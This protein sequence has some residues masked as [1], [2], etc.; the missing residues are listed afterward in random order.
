[1]I[2][3]FSGTGNSKA[4]A[5]M[6]AKQLNDSIVP[7]TDALSLQREYFLRENEPLGFVFPVYSWGPPE[8]VLRLVASLR[9]TSKPSY[10]YFV[11]TCGDDTGKTADIFCKAVAARGWK[12]EA[13][14][15]VTMP[16][17]YV[18]LPGF[19]VDSEEMQKRKIIG[20]SK[21]LID[22][23]ERIKA[24]KK[25]FDCNE[26]A[27]PRLKSYGIRPLFN[28][29]LVNAKHFWVNEDC[30]SCGKCIRVCPTK[31]IKWKDGRPSWGEDCTMCLACYHLCPKHA[32]QYGGQTKK[33]G[34]Y[35][36]PF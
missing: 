27:M 34:Q 2:T 22:L 23:A 5:N 35:K 1:M 29:F 19:D 10:V 12:C 21:R 36:F 26:G 33:K 18:C 17:T 16:N 32:I 25:G 15:S 20:T 24:R 3:V 11:C 13:G 30:I 31:N 14:F 6:L 28:Q 4:V 9:L 8:I 7:L